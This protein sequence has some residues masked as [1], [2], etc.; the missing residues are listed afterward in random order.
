VLNQKT[1]THILDYFVHVLLI[2]NKLIR[3]AWHELF[4]L[5]G[6]MAW[7]FIIID[8]VINNNTNNNNGNNIILS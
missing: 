7:T 4:F 3:Q 5:R 6:R 1:V 8:L 2:S